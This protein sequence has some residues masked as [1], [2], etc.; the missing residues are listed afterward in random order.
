MPANRE[1]TEE[2][3]W[4]VTPSG[5]GVR[6]YTSTEARTLNR[7]ASSEA[8]VEIVEWCE[9]F[10]GR[11]SSLVGRSGNVCPFVPEAIVRESLKFAVV[12]LKG[13][14]QEAVREIEE[15]IPAFRHKF[16]ANEKALNKIDIFGSWILLFPD[17]SAAEAEQIIDVPQRKMKPDF[18][19]EG[20]MLGEFHPT[21]RSPGIRNQSFRPLRSPHPLLVIRH[22]VESDIE[23]LSRPFDPAPIRVESLKAYLRFLGSS[24]SVSSLI[25]AKTALKL[26]ESQVGESQS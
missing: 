12:P 8:L 22:M 18:V 2:M 21:S 9:S 5:L 1:Q 26:A 14:N 3:D 23:F 7:D 6:L 15:V 4:V 20:L 25:R 16:L 13:R 24:V 17:V 10:L 11:P 19:R